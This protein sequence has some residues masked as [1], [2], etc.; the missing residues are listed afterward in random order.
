[1]YENLDKN[2]YDLTKTTMKINSVNSG[3]YFLDLLDNDSINDLNIKGFD[4]ALFCAAKTDQK[5][6]ENNFEKTHQINVI[7][8]LKLIK[9]L[10][11]ENCS[12]IFP[13]TSLVFNG[14]RPYPST[15]DQLD[16]V[17][18]YANFKKEV[19]EKL[20]D[21]NLEKI[22]ILRISK[23]V[24]H[25]FPLFLEWQKKL[26]NDEEI[27]PFNDLI[28]SPISISF[29]TRVMDQ[30][31]KKNISGIFN[32][33]AQSDISYADASRYLSKKL[34]LSLDKIKPVSA[35]EI[36]NDIYLPKFAAMNTSSLDPLGL[37]APEP[38]ESID[39]FLRSNFEY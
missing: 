25:N 39:F 15:Q 14:K 31:I 38:H 8:T 9:K 30:I 21:D 22:T 34:G 27:Q 5:E 33:S 1:M 13:S 16:P 20:L 18:N 17:G 4:A 3:A 7:S 6:C 19:E 32:I 11:K 35:K 36:F 37:R 23:V 10:S 28:F 24:D 12:V 29:L 2:Y 26:L